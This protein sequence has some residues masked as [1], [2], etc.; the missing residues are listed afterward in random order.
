MSIHERLGKLLACIAL[1]F[2]VLVVTDTYSKYLTEAS[3]T[4]DIAIARWRILVNGQDIRNNA[5]L[6]QVISP[7][8]YQNNHIASNVI[9][10]RSTGY[11]DL[12][13]DCRDADVSFEYEI[14][15]SPN[16]DSSVTDLVATGYLI[17]GGS[18]VSMD[19]GD[20]I[21]NQVLLSS[22]TQTISIR[23]YIE[24]DDTSNDATMDNEDDTE[25]TKSGDDALLDVNL[26]FIQ[27]N[28]NNNNNNNNEP[29]EP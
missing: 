21:S 7:T 20:T 13:I 2:V 9:A 19:R 17:D 10:P 15:I 18:T 6:S 26:S 24:W 27:L 1:L 25:A 8:I 5:D 11:F 12:V 16:E 4:T 3:G 14:D 29:S 22:H 28:E 23:V